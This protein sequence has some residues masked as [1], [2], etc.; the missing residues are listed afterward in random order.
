LPKFLID[1][2][3]PFS[4]KNL[5]QELGFDAQHVRETDLKSASDEKIF[6]SA[7]R[8][9]QILLTRDLD[10]ADAVRFKPGKHQGI[11]VLRISY[12][13]TATQINCIVKEFFKEVDL[14]K[15]KRGLVIVEV[16]RYRLRTK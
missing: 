8:K 13:M 6:R 5:L 2:N 9:G 16:G 11:I 7:Q 14:K 10:F 4:T 3:L 15:I 1:A 12:L